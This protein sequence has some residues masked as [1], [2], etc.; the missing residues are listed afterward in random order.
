MPRE[1]VI[2]TWLT[3][4]FEE[5]AEDEMIDYCDRSWIVMSEFRI[6]PVLWR[7]GCSFRNSVDKHYF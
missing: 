6:Q 2:W 4:G 7:K 5:S 3:S 1:V